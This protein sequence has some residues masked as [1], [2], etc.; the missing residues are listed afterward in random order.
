MLPEIGSLIKGYLPGESF[1]IRVL[2]VEERSYLILARIDSNLISNLH[3][4]KGGEILTFHLVDCGVAKCWE[5]AAYRKINV[6]ATLRIIPNDE[7]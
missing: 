3:P 6:D 4:F 7:N 2:A 1:W 5:P